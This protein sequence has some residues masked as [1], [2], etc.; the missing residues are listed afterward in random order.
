MT[1][2]KEPLATQAMNDLI[3]LT[4]LAQDE[5][6]AANALQE[7]FKLAIPVL[8]IDVE[9]EFAMVTGEPVVHFKLNETLMA[10]LSAL[11]ASK[12]EYANSEN[13]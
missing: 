13:V 10:H 6:L 7:C 1:N 4:I 12:R 2:A 3:E 11:R 9:D 8:V 5:P